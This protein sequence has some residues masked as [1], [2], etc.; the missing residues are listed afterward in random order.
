MTVSNVK[1]KHILLLSGWNVPHTT[2]SLIPHFKKSVILHLTIRQQLLMS[3]FSFIDY[4]QST[5][6][7]NNR[8]PQ[9]ARIKRGKGGREGRKEERG[10]RK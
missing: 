7:G 4:I 9:H 10:K 8:R 5:Y 2:S 3:C 1:E 6:N